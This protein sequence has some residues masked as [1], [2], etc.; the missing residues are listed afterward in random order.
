MDLDGLCKVRVA[1]PYF[2]ISRVTLSVAVVDVTTRV[3]MY[4]YNLEVHT[5]LPRQ[6]N[7]WAGSVIP[8]VGGCCGDVHYVTFLGY[9]WGVPPTNDKV[10]DGPT[11][12]PP[13]RYFQ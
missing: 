8:P 10:D 12:R 7:G 3:R 4:S 13:L 11:N 5:L 2:G 9:V 1:N 6:K